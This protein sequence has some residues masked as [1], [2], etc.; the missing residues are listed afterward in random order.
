MIKLKNRFITLIS[1]AMLSQMAMTAAER[2]VNL[3]IVHTT[4][5]HGNFFPRD[6]INLTPGVGSMARVATLVDSLRQQMGRENVILLDAGDIL[7]GQPTVYYYN[8]EDTV[9]GHVAS[10]IYNYMDYDA[11][12]VGNHDI[13]TGHD[14]YDRF[15]SQLDR[16]LLAANVIDK[17]SRKPYFE[18]YRIINRNGVKIAVLGLLTPAIPAWLPENLWS[19]LE[20]EDMLESAR[21]WVPYIREKE[22]PDILI[23]LFHS[24]NDASRK[25]GDYLENASAVVAKNVPGLDIVLTGHDH[26]RYNRVAM[27]ADGDSVVIVNPANN[28]E[29]VS[30]VN[31]NLSYDN[32]GKL[33]SRRISAD[34][35]PVNGLEPSPAF[36]AEFSGDM[37]AVDSYVNRV[38]GSA[39]G[40]FTTQEAF[41]GPSSFMQLIHD[42]QREISG[43]DISM[44]AP[45]TYNATIAKGEVKVSDMF[46]LYKYENL[47]YVMNLTGREIKNY[48]EESY[49]MWTATMKPGDRHLLLFAADNPSKANPALK[50]P[51]YN[52]DSASGIIYTV[53]ATRAPGDKVSIISMEDGTPFDMEKVYRVAVN[54]YRGNGG[55]DLLTRGAGIPHDELKD[56]VQWATDRDMRYFLIKAVEKKKVIEPNIVPNW[57]FVPEDVVK[58][59]IDND[60]KILFEK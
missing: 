32:D 50:N 47:L 41:F 46:N 40:D 56:R 52:F 58:D 1:I 49:R 55:G 44:A 53:D 14:V 48:L 37:E 24:G 9:T 6:Y 43:A 8:F 2:E 20:F 45:L 38:L 7:Q 54:S 11:V 33:M 30:V 27:A 26:T 57:K 15:N 12:T 29:A 31:V 60:Y 28:A 25:T 5:V 10:R 35:V 4:D 23:G 36:M 21:K 34:I 42:L 13:E 19:G 39:S 18:P 51:T 16:P 17:S 3:K 59:A 22:N